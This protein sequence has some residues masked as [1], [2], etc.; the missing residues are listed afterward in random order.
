MVLTRGH[1]MRRAQ[2]DSL[3]NAARAPLARL[4]AIIAQQAEFDWY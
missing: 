2:L 4:R 3:T 1:L